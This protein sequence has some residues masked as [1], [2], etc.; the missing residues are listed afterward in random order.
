MASRLLEQGY[1]LETLQFML[2]DAEL[3]YE[4]PYL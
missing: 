3:D 2:G 1:S 4:D